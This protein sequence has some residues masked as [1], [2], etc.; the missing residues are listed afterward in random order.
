MC[1]K[2]FTRAKYLI[3]QERKA[4]EIMHRLTENIKKLAEQ[5][6]WRTEV[7][8]DEIIIKIK[9][10]KMKEETKVKCADCLMLKETE[11]T[12]SCMRGIRS[13][14]WVNDEKEKAQEINELIFCD[15]FIPKTGER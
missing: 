9:E 14:M 15:G 5:K 8:N 7:I 2:R 1:V 6:G 13:I 12:I 11:K 4:S 10:P 3:Q